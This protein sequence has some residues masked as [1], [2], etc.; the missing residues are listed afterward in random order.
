MRIIPIELHV[1]RW[2]LG[3]TFLFYIGHFDWPEGDASLFELG[4][5]QGAF[6]WDLLGLNYLWR[7]FAP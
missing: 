1:E 2:N 3:N 4:W 5:Y 6:Q 7:R